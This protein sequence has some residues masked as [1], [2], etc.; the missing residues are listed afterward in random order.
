GRK[1]RLSELSVPAEANGN[2]EAAA[3]KAISRAKG[4]TA[5]VEAVA[6]IRKAAT[7]PFAQ[8]LAEERATFQQLRQS[9]EAAAKRYLFFAERDAFRVPGLEHANPRAVSNVG[10]V[11]A[12]TMGAGIAI[13]FLDAG[14]PVTL[15]E[16]DQG[17]L[18]AGL[19]RIRST[20]QRM[21]DTGRI[22]NEQME[23]R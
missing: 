1:R 20:C 17:A 15:I 5:I 4:S 13:C 3:E 2:A 21:V 18:D 23:Q 16:R 10:V 12:G 8:A 7:L 19:G 6:S 11:G 14:I 22:T 9:T